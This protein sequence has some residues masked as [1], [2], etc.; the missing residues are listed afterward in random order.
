MAEEA[1]TTETT[2]E[3]KPVET[4][5]ETKPLATE[6]KPAETT[7]TKPAAEDKKGEE[8]KTAEPIVYGEFKAP[9][10]MTLDKAALEGV[11]PMFQKLGLN[12]EQ[13]QELVS[14]YANQVKAAG[15]ANAK[16]WADTVKGWQTELKTDADYGGVHLEKTQSLAAKAIDAYGGKDAPALREFMKTYGLGDHPAFA[17]FLARAG[18]SVR[19]DGLPRAHGAAGEVR[20]ARAL[21][22]NS[23]MN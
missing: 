8:T 15:E 9:E 3:T 11:T 23:N 2:T 12:Q 17:R 16:A 4:T 21:Y 1:V 18:R 20:D 19:E 14:Y 7:E 5:T 13:A 22:P 10:G 6:T